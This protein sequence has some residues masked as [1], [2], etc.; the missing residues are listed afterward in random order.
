[1]EV[2]RPMA[3][4]F[5]ILG[6]VE[7]VAGDGRSAE[8]RGQ[9]AKLLL[10]A[11]LLNINR[12]VPVSRL[13][14]A[15]WCHDPPTS[16]Q[17]NLRTYAAVLRRALADAGP[18]APA[19]LRTSRLGYLV[20]A[21]EVALD[22]ARF[23]S[24]AASGRERLERGDP[25]GAAGSFA[26]ALALWRGSAAGEGL[27]RDGWLG[28]ALAG[29]DDERLRVVED[30]ADAHLALGRH[31]ELVSPLARLLAENP[32]RERAW[33]Q[34]MLAQ[35]RCGDAAAALNSYS[36]ARAA[37]VRELGVE[38]GPELREL[39]RQVIAREPALGRPDGR[40][41]GRHVSVPVRPSPRQLPAGCPHFIGRTDELAAVVEA[42][43]A[44]GAHPALVAIDGMV[45]VGK[46]ALAVSAARIAADLFPD[47][48]L[49]SDVR[50]ELPATDPPRTLLR[51]MLSALG[52][53]PIEGDAD[54]TELA[55]LLRTVLDGRR[56]LLVLDNVATEASVLPLLPATAGCAT[57]VTSQRP[58]AL[59]QLT[60]RVS[61]GML[62][63]P[64]AVALLR[65][66]VGA[67]RVDADPAAAA[68]LARSCGGLPLALLIAGTRLAARKDWTV[69]MLVDRFTSRP[70]PLD[71]LSYSTVSVSEGIGAALNRV[72]QDTPSVRAVFQR[73]AWLPSSFESRSAAEMVGGSLRT[74]EAALE[75][76]VDARLLTSSTAGRYETHALV[77]R[78]AGQLSRSAGAGAAGTA[79]RPDV[80]GV[81]G[82]SRLAGRGRALHE[83]RL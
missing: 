42:M 10:V 69:R 82:N 33:H 35:Y 53:A 47:G 17:E 37:L 13:I 73:L 52:E 30:Q 19:R 27:P 40:C 72:A 7:I 56:V 34:L 5:R 1:V 70:R 48:Q 31:R 36:R 32:L 39:Q 67:D 71:E 79:G 23:D 8:I 61:L 65:R 18:T 75:A 59:D 78:Y 38:P 45:G 6:R 41:A 24:L 55:A 15:L 44:G 3:A 16:A 50:A 22:A 54:A 51:R 11:L 68:D 80:V 64:E 83:Q 14:D 62:A 20:A 77:R 12:P 46:S 26:E 58:L 76:L 49:Y 25:L 60:R 2:D 28:G 57:V 66:L 43:Q 21:E 63:E 4:A 29:L 9:K 74:V 81:R